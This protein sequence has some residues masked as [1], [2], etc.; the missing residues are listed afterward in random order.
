MT[1]H[2]SKDLERIV[3]DAVPTGLYAREDDV[4][5]AAL[6][7]FKETLPKNFQTPAKKAKRTKPVPQKG[8]L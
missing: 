1:I 3:H 4:L 6:T 8:S 7:Q 2:L 5:R